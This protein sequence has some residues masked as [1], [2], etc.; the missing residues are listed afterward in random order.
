MKWRSW[1]FDCDGV[2]LNSNGVKREAMYRSAFQ[3]GSNNAKRLVEYHVSN[4][5]I[6][7]DIK[8]HWFLREVVGI[9]EGLEEAFFDLKRE[10]TKNIWDGLLACEVSPGIHETLARLRKEGVSLFVVSGADQD[11]LREI[12]RERQLG[13]MFDGI[14]GAPD[15]K[16]EILTRELYAGKM[17]KSSVFLGDSHYDYEASRRAGLDFIFIH[18]WT[19]VVDWQR[20]VADKGIVSAAHVANVLKV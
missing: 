2:I 15:T 4:G 11:E 17:D 5:G 8:F 3:Y 13:S 1:V 19:E 7:R 18:G 14:Y 9:N 16:D 20:F 10:Y 12:L 6:G